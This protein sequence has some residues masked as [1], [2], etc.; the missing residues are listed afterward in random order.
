MILRMLTALF[1]PRSYTGRHRLARAR[2]TVSQR[3]SST[4]GA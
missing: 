2:Y 4:V 1:G 3:G